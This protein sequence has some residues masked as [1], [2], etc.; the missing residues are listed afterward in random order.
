MNTTFPKT[1][2]IILSALFVAWVFVPNVLFAQTTPVSGSLVVR[3][4]PVSNIGTSWAT[5]NGYASNPGTK[6]T[7][8][9]EW[10]ETS[11]FGKVT[12]S[13]VRWSEQTAS[14]PVEGL[15]SGTRYYYHAVAI[16]GGET[17]YGD[18]LSFVV[19]ANSSSTA[20]AASAPS[21][22]NTGSNT[23]GN[24]YATSTSSAYNTAKTTTNKTTTSTTNKKI[25]VVNCA[26]TTAIAGNLT[27]TQGSGSSG[28]T[29]QASSSGAGSLIVWLGVIVVILG[30][31]AGAMHMM[32]VQEEVRRKEEM[33]RVIIA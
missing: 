22:S 14:M 5:L 18:T 13:K 16:S 21:P 3:T 1:K 33:Q 28:L 20:G 6:V 7:L 17:V 26:T 31:V 12:Q 15:T 8:W 4:Q 9:F 24:T 2:N 27:A 11:S 29:A 19:G 23:T 25:D 30:A 32:A 10:G